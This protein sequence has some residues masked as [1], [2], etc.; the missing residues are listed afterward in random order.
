MWLVRN[1]SA[2]QWGFSGP[3]LMDKAMISHNQASSYLPHSD[4]HPFHP[5]GSSPHPWEWI[6]LPTLCLLTP[7]QDLPPPILHLFIIVQQPPNPVPAHPHAGPPN[8]A[9]AHPCAGCPPPCACKLPC[10][11]PAAT[12]HLHIPVHDPTPTLC[13]HTPSIG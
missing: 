9:P 7:R 6:L 10:R 8:P 13:L 12:L 1:G 3:V 4:G 11:T 5:P 2:G